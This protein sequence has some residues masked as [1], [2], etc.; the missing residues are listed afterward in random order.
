MFVDE[1][2][3]KIQAGRGGDGLRSFRREKFISKGGPDGGDGAKGGDVIAKAD[4]NVDTLAKYRYSRLVKAENGENGGK[5]RMHGKNG[6]DTELVVPPGTVI[7]EGE[8]LLADLAVA[9][10]TVVVA[11]GGRGGFG[12]A[13]FTTSVRQAPDFAEIG[14]EGE[15]KVLRLELKTV[16]D[17]GL[18]GLPN[19]G[20]ST[21]LSVI[22]NARPKIANYPF[23]T[24]TPN[25]GTIDV[26]G[27]TLILA[28]IPGLIA[29][30]SEGKGLGDD[31]LR[32]I[33]RTKVL[34]H[35]VDAGAADVAADYQTI[36]AELKNYAIDLSGKPQL[37]VLSKADTITDTK[38]L[39]IKVSALERIVKTPLIV[40]SAQ[41]HTGLEEL[42]SHMHQMVVEARRQEHAETAKNDMPTLTLADDPE[43]WRIEEAAGQ[44]IIKGEKIEGFAR[45]TDFKNTQALARLRQILH[46][47]GIDR[48]LQRRG[49][50]PNGK[51]EIA[52][53]KI[54]LK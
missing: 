11:S 15:Q 6:R 34:V 33:E 39:A 20:K 17:V 19:A 30:A 10:K 4:H 24:L 37:V 8:S 14:E 54:R 52:G 25:L 7:Y 45:R 3:I 50:A 1:V 47:Y 53:K 12:N 31:F 26:Y 46:K 5:R 13:H 41:N 2:T 28:D 23:T 9:G 43:A 29:G 49:L 51:V 42:H 36:Q 16:A 35:L 40:I 32:H 38:I 18:I 48:E 27:T 22:S 44:L 21:L